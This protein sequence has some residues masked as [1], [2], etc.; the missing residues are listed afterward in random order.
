MALQQR[1]TIVLLFLL[2]ML[3]WIRK[4]LIKMSNHIKTSK[5]AKTI[6]IL[7]VYKMFSTYG[8]IITKDLMEHFYWWCWSEKT[9]QRD[10]K[11]LKKIG[12]LIDY[13]QAERIY[14]MESWSKN[15]H[16]SE[17][18]LKPKEI[19][20][21][22][23]LTRL[24]TI[25]RRIPDADC[26]I[27]YK[28]TFPDISKRTML[29]DFSLLNESKLGYNIYYKKRLKDSEKDHLSDWAEIWDNFEEAMEDEGIAP[30]KRYYNDNNDVDDWLRDEEDEYREK[31]PY[32]FYEAQEDPI[33]EMFLK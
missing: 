23:K 10:V 22:N 13:C 14:V 3:L 1:H 19:Q 26:D 21:L 8:K 2:Y 33:F 18:D 15:L 28:Q 11:L 5:N 24:I 7:H 30:P 12:F 16:I 9:L 25:M 4:E 17:T 27:W 31:I 6:R 32:Y 20:Y 29:R